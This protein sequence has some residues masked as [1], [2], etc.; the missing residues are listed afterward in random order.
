MGNLTATSVYVTATFYDA[1]GKMVGFEY[2][3]TSPDTIPAGQTADFIIDAVV[4]ND[5]NETSETQSIASISVRAKS[6]E[7][8]SPLESP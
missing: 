2:A 6:N 8:L 4:G 1:V 7:Y 5:G 3:S